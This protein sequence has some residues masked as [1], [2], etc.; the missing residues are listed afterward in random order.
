MAVRARSA[1]A[2]ARAELCLAARRASCTR[3]SVWL[4]SSGSTVF[5]IL[6]SFMDENPSKAELRAEVA[7]LEDTI[8]DVENQQFE[9][10][11][12][13]TR[14]RDLLERARA[15]LGD[16]DVVTTPSPQAHQ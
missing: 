11:T 7:A 4:G 1:Q 6:S 14:L 16:A 9:L 10:A 5:R 15:H 12:V 3:S 8:A 13:L 2:W